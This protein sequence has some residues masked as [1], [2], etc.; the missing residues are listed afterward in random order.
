[1]TTETTTR[2]LALF[3]VDVRVA[4]TM[5]VRAET[6]A[7]ALAI[8]RGYSSDSIEVGETAGG[9]AGDF[10]KMLPVTS[11][12]FDHP[13]IPDVSLS[14]AMTI[15]APF[16]AGTAAPEVRDFNEWAGI[17]AHLPPRDAARL[18]LESL[19][20]YRFHPADAADEDDLDQLGEAL[21][22]YH[23]THGGYLDATPGFAGLMV[24]GD[25]D[26]FV[27]AYCASRKIRVDGGAFAA[28]GRALAG[29][30]GGPAA[31]ADII[32]GAA[33]ALD[34]FMPDETADER[35][36][37]PDPIAAAI[38]DATRAARVNAE[39]SGS[40]DPAA[41][42]THW[43]D[44]AT[45]ERVNAETGERTPADPLREAV[46]VIVAAHRGDS[47]DPDDA[48]ALEVHDI[49]EQLREALAGE[50][51]VTYE[52]AARAAGWQTADLTPGMI[53]NPG[54][55]VDGQAPAVSSWKAAAEYRGNA[56]P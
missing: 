13:D 55:E 7:A 4:A 43:I 42:D 54:L 17:L 6:E 3:P 19:S 49:V 51:T 15:I 38:L 25:L 23:V 12:P 9:D 36:M 31:A 35:A 47:P 14:P 10:E 29:F 11:L 53:V 22:G 46:E 27:L 32:E 2:R 28:L 48:A 44:D 41:P 8:A 56:K 5:Y 20:G 50:R 30:N 24:E 26:A 16:D 45:G 34:L 18:V 39:W 33:S 21:R 37:G 40:P 1:M 52:T